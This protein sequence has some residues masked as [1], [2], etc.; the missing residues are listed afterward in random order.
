MASAKPIANNAWEIDKPALGMPTRNDHPVNKISLELPGSDSQRITFRFA[1]SKGMSF[2][3]AVCVT[4]NRPLDRRSSQSAA[5]IVQMK[6]DTGNFY[7]CKSRIVWKAAITMRHTIRC[8]VSL[9]TIEPI[10][11]STCLIIIAQRNYHAISFF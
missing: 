6:I 11:S 4:S 3:M 10:T 8:N 9:S 5:I 1:P 2:V 7:V